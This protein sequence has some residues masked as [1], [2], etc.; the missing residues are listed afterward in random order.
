M[1]NEFERNSGSITPLFS[2]CML[3]NGATENNKV[4]TPKSHLHSSLITNTMLCRPLRGC[5]KKG[6][7]RTFTSNMRNTCE[8]YRSKIGDA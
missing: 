4:M 7:F 2:N 1:S 5:P 3:D 8:A 6:Q